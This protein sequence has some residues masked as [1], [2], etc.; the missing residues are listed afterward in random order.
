VSALTALRRS[1]AARITALALLSGLAVLLGIVLFL[2]AFSTAPTTLKTVP[3]VAAILGLPLV[4]GW[5]AS[6]LVVRPLRDFARAIAALQANRYET[7][8]IASGITEFDRVFD[9]F[10][11]LAQRLRR[12]EELRKDLISDT[13]HE[14][15]TPLTALTGQLIAM[16]EG[17]LPI[18]PERIQLLR[19]Q[20][21]R[22]TELVVRLDAYTRARAPQHTRAEDVPLARVCARVVAELGQELRA[23]AID[24]T[25]EIPDDLTVKADRQAF[26][27]ILLNILRNT[28]DH[29]GATEVRIVA[30]KEGLILSDNG[31]GVPTE[32]LPHLFEQFYR[33]EKSRNRASGG[34]G[35]GLAI[36]RELVERQ[37]WTIRAEATRQGLSLHIR[38]HP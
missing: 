3:L 5:F 19:E 35:L 25:V 14:L 16:Q 32:S 27:Q 9:S 1:F 33:V 36:V 4:L 22:L 26:E 28:L 11:A 30:D 2:G 23:R 20:V 13:S 37:G 12:E 8:L 29:A 15:Y 7:R 18:S 38:F 6:R 10:N 31:R 17:T 21:D 34:L 24:A